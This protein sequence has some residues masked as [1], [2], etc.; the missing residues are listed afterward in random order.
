MS[1]TIK[2]KQAPMR[3]RVRGG[4]LYL[5]FLLFPAT[6]YYF[7]PILILTSTMKGIINASFI[8]FALMFISSLFVG[9]L[10]C[11][12]VC[13][14][15]ALQD[16][17]LPIN[18]QPTPGGKFNWMKWFIW[19]PWLL[20][21]AVLAIRAGGYQRVDPLYQLEHGVTFLSTGA[22]N[23]GEPWFIPYCSFAKITR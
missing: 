7:S 4:L 1:K 11:G 18:N 16:F 8:S 12:W 22:N 20:S 15:A 19:T 14:A 21:I 9:R 23:G 10:W 3:Q 6:L 5:S 2:I 13:P 17:A